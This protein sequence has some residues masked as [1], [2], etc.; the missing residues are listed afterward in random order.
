M[1]SLLTPSR[2]SRWLRALLRSVGS[3]LVGL[4]IVDGYEVAQVLISQG[5][6]SADQFFVTM[7]RKHGVPVKLPSDAYASLDGRPSP[8]RGFEGKIE[9]YG[10]GPR[11]TVQFSGG[12]ISTVAQAKRLKEFWSKGRVK[13]IEAP[14]GA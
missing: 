4:S 14:D 1:H 10:S 5:Y 8:G 3:N 11:K 6:P 12:E 7:L 9:R 13:L 2:K